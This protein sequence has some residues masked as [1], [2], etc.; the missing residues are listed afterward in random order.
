MLQYRTDDAFDNNYVDDNLRQLW[1]NKETS[2][3][4]P[5]ITPLRR[6]EEGE[7][8]KV[9][10]STKLTK[11]ELKNVFGRLKETFLFVALTILLL[12]VDHNIVKLIDVFKR[13]GNYGITH[14]GKRNF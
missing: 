12:G 8:Y 4:F 1:K 6:W 9:S 13:H 10:N 11:K 5:K 3:E 14:L 7:K 2:L